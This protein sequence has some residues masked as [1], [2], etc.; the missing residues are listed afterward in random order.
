MRSPR[1][2]GRRASS[3]PTSPDALV[4][5][6]H[7]VVILDD[8]SS[9]KRENVPAGAELEVLDIRSDGGRG[10]RR[11]RRL[12]PWRT[13]RR[14]WTCAARSPTR[15][16][17][18]TSMCWGASTC[19]RPPAGR[20]AARAVRLDRRGHLR[21]AGRLPRHR[22]PPDAADVALRRGQAGGGALP[23]VLPPGSTDWTSPALRYANVY[24]ARQ[25]PHG[26]AGVV[27]IFRAPAP[28]LR[29]GVQGRWPDP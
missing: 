13:R 11:R 14:R 15:A 17:T 7:E 2:R 21:R 27:A 6:G 23:L 12:T 1:H 26:E 3:D 10:V 19:S 22:G 5:A 8:L 18:P 9:G 25:N 29:H 28:R 24:G 4:E 16:S 20:R